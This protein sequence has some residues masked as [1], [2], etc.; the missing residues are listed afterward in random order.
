[1]SN[2]GA[3][4]CVE[5]GD[6]YVYAWLR[7]CGEPFYIGKGRGPR[8]DVTHG[9]NQIFLRIVDKAGVNGWEPKV[10]RLYEHLSE[11]E[12][13]SMERL[14]IAKHG[15]LNNK[16][17]VL[18]NLTDGGEGSSGY[19][20]PEASRA[21]IRA[22]M[23]GREITAAHRA[24]LSIAITGLVRSEETRKKIGAVHKGKKLSVIH[25][26]KILDATRAATPRSI[27]K[28]V[29]KVKLNGTW[30][31]RI[32]INGKSHNLG[33]YTAP[34]DAARAYDAAAYSA[35]GNECYLNFPDLAGNPP[36]IRPTISDRKRQAAPKRGYKGVSFHKG[37]GKW[38]ALIRVDGIQRHLGS[39]GNAESAAQEYDRAAYEAWGDGCYLNFPDQ[40][41]RDCQPANDNKPQEFGATNA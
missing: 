5:G 40:V 16:T 36:P 27:F 29:A 10:V 2:S 6:F 1:M 19:S 15:R 33:S 24:N 31:A 14:E 28:G 32:Y 21:K 38:R 39:F 7:P 26:R 34:E 4:E 11:A 3:D 23:I 20:M 37:A 25:I 35:W 22:A 18:A 30:A 13:F 9:R 17:G 41:A 12:A 8:A